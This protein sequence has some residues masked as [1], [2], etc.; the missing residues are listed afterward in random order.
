MKIG[1]GTSIVIAIAL[2]MSFILYFV[3]TVQTNSQYDNDMVYE[4][5]YKVDAQYDEVIKKMQGAK[6]LD[7]V[8]KI[9]NTKNEVT[10]NF[11]QNYTSYE[12]KVSFYRP[13]DKNLDFE[14]PIAQ[15]GSSLLIPKSE[16]AGGRWDIVIEWTMDNQD[17]ALREVMYL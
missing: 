3:I 8:P 11:P 10:I 17:F 16:L 4:E 13:S 2:F 6:S 9:I 14:K 15:S 12:G 5:Y 7:S 1:W